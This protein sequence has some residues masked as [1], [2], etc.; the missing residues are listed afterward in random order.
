MKRDPAD[1]MPPN[2]DGAECMV[3]EAVAAFLADCV[4]LQRQVESILASFN[5]E[6]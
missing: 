2:P 5:S 1:L 6:D 3:V 4:D